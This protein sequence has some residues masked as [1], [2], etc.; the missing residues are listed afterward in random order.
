MRLVALGCALVFLSALTT[1]AR[2]VSAGVSFT[3]TLQSYATG[4]A[5]TMT[6]TTKNGCT[7][8]LIVSGRPKFICAGRW[9][10]EGDACPGRRGRLEF[11]FDPDGFHDVFLRV[12]RQSVCTARLVG[13][14]PQGPQAPPYHWS[15]VCFRL[16]P[17]TQIDSGAAV[18]A[19]QSE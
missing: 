2:R 17:T 12:S 16:H 1:E 9:R 15:Y 6:W 18:V 11:A 5:A 4:S 8:G 14:L 19:L 3:A 10:C 7:Q 13:L